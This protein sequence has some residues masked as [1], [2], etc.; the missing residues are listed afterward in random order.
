[1]IRDSCF[2]LDVE[3][4]FL[5]VCGPL[6]MAI[7]LQ[8]SLCLHELQWLMISVD[9]CL[10]PKNVMSPLTLGLHNGVDFFVVSR[11]LTDNI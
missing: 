10:L 11:V 4:E 2:I 7:I 8:F 5:Q 9:D 1:M 6:M 3:V